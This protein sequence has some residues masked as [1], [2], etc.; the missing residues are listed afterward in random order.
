MLG[1]RAGELHRKTLRTSLS[2]A[3]KGVGWMPEGP[4]AEE[5]RG[6]RRNVPGELQAS[7]EPGGPEWGNPRPCERS[8]GVLNA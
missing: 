3:Q 8:H 4:G 1:C 7:D 5:G 6:E 2:Q